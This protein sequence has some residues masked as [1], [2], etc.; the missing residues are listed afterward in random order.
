VM[1]RLQYHNGRLGKQPEQADWAAQM[2]T[3]QNVFRAATG[4][5]R[6][7]FCTA[8]TELRK[9]EALG[10]FYGHIMMTGRLRIRL[11]LLFNHIFACR[12]E[13][14]KESAAYQVQTIPDRINPVVR[15]TIRGLQMFEDVTVD[16]NKDV[17]GQG[18]GRIL[19]KKRP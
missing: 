13:T 16:W 2:T 10:K 3:L 1:D 7:L 6:N 15:T 12:V 18:L 14:D 5:N 17:A 4:Q 11:P 8:H 19:S 9:D